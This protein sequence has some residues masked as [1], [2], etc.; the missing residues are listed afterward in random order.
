MFPKPPPPRT[1]HV[2]PVEMVADFR[3]AGW[4]YRRIVEVVR[5]TTGEKFTTDGLARAL[6]KER[7]PV[8]PI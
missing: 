5:R 2:V 7:Q 6:R 4:S 3:R 1:H 8:G